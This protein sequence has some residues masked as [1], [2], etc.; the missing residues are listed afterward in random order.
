MTVQDLL[1]LGLA[2]IMLAVGLSL[3]VNQFKS[4]ILY[5]RAFYMGLFNQLILLPIIGLILIA[6][7]DGSPDFAF[8]IMIL[9]ACPGGITSNLLSVLAR[10]N[11]ALSVSMTAATSLAS[12]ISVPAVL[13]LSH[14]IIYGHSTHI[15]A[16]FGQIMAGTFIITGIPIV[17]GM[18][19]KFKAPYLTLLIHPYIRT[20]ATVIFALIVIGSFILN[21]ENIV[22]NFFDVGPY[23]IA[24][25]IISMTIGYFSAR[26]LRRPQSDSITICL[27]SGLQNVTIAMFIALNI[28]GRSDLMIPAIIYAV[29][30]NISAAC[31]IFLVRKTM[32][33]TITEAG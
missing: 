19:I 28:I 11:T 23:L 21:K 24:L 22:E 16:P 7:Y 32:P 12:I 15:N 20:I 17:I 33:E 14:M 27:E 18:M 2:F 3:Q 6:F 31:I 9:A 8:G 5:P 13:A 29:I 10:G 25:N 4:I 26:L 1:P 30:M